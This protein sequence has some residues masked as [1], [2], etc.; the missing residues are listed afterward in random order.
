VVVTIERTAIGGSLVG[1]EAGE[2]IRQPPYDDIHGKPHFIKMRPGERRHLFWN[3]E[4]RCWQI[5]PVSH[6]P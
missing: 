4:N 2:Y 5:C 1:E 6:R 3:L